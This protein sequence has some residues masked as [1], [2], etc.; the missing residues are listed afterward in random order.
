MI[1]ICF[2]GEL[3]EFNLTGNLAMDIC[4]LIHIWDAFCYLFWISFLSL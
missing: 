1:I 4:I 3:V 2:V